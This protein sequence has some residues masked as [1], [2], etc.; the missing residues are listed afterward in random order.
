[1]AQCPEKGARKASG[2]V[3]TA[4]RKCHVYRTAAYARQVKP[5]Y[6][7]EMCPEE[8]E[9]D[10]VVG[11]DP[12]CWNVQ[13][14]P[15]R[16]VPR[17]EIRRRSLPWRITLKLLGAGDAVAVHRTGS[18]VKEECCTTASGPSAKAPVNGQLSRAGGQLLIVAHERRIEVSSPKGNCSRSSKAR[19][20][21]ELACAGC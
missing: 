14:S 20:F 19:R 6:M 13:K 3:Q 11:S 5:D 12:I 18:A 1:M 4:H 16:P 2:F 9:F 7:I 17:P 15:G 10:N 8:K 21:F